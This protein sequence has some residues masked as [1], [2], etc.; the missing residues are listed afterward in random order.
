MRF[1]EHDEVGSDFTSAAQRVEQLIAIDLGRADDQRGVPVL[2]SIAGQD[3]DAFR[4]KLVNEFLI[5]GIG[6]R[7]QRRRVPCAAAI[8]EKT[9]DLLA[10]DPRL[11]APGRG[12][13]Q[14][15]LIFNGLE[16]LDLKIVGL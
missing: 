1:V 4:A 2:F 12:G 6:E 10:R 7:L 9:S 13:N 15:V 11:A 3:A 16:S 14:D 5:L 8:F